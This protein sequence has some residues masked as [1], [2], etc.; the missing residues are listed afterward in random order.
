MKETKNRNI[1]IVLAAGQGSRMGT[2]RKKQYLL[3]D[4]KPML[5]YSLHAFEESEYVTDI[6]IVVGAGEEQYVR[7]EI[8]MP[9]GIKK[10]RGIVQGG[11]ERYHSVYAGIKAI[12]KYI[13]NALTTIC[14]EENITDRDFIREKHNYIEEKSIPEIRTECNNVWV[15]DGARPFI[16]EEILQRAYQ[17]VKETKACVVAMP[18]K[19]TIKI[20]DTEGNIASTPN[21][22]L[23][24]QIQTPQVF[25]YQLIRKAYEK[26]IEEEASLSQRGIV[27]TDDAMV[28]ETFTDS[29]V[30]LVKGDYKNIKITTPEDLQIAKVFNSTVLE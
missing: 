9:Y 24:W 27:V 8:V 22:N 4:G 18:V 21:R 11:K 29:K 2:T 30:R 12:K 23:V 7:D 10:V 25:E 1:A 6:I 5:Y 19:D 16:N 28:V 14:E 26:L 17:M 3:L 15:H 20:S 13:P